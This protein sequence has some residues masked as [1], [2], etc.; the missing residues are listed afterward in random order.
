MEGR[1]IAWQNFQ[2]QLSDTIRVTQ[3]T[4]G[5]SGEALG[6]R[7][8][9][10]GLVSF[11]YK[12]L[13]NDEIYDDVTFGIHAKVSGPQFDIGKQN[14]PA[15]AR[16][17][18]QF[19]AHR[20]TNPKYKGML[21]TRMVSTMVNGVCRGECQSED[22]HGLDLQFEDGA[23]QIQFDCGWSWTG[24]E[25]SLVWCDVTKKNSGLK[26]RYAA[27]M[28]G[29]YSA[30]DYLGVGKGASDGKAYFNFQAPVSDFKLTIF[31]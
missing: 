4:L 23:D 15:I 3:D 2:C 25:T 11:T 30:I 14:L 7:N 31:Q 13:T 6:N 1:K 20:E 28:L 22:S 8:T 29:E 17:T 5:A 19:L 10:H 16:G 24:D 9:N 27:K 12:Q 21:V 26:I 18:W